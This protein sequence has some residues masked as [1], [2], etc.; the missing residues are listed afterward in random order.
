MEKQRKI[1]K[2]ERHVNWIP[3]E[4][5]KDGILRTEHLY[6]V[7]CTDCNHYVNL[8]TREIIDN[9]FSRE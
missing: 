6:L 4:N 8:L 3:I 9:P 1:K 5:P 7:Y 2:C